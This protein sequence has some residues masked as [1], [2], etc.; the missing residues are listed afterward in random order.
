MLAC[1]FS[2]A[3]SF[4][5]SQFPS[6]YDDDIRAAVRKY[7]GGAPD[8]TWLKAQYWQESL[9]DPSQVSP[10]GAAG[11]AQFMPGSWRDVE[12][13]LGWAD[14][15][16][17]AAKYAIPAGA[18]YMAS[19]RGAWTAERTLMERHRLAQASYN[20]GI[21]NVLAAQRLCRDARLWDDIA[22]CLPDVTG[23][24]NA[25]QTVDYVAKIA[26]WQAEMVR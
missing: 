25:R 21:G 20:A 7:W 15:D 14:V 3:P 9:L 5:A 1:V 8:W 18:F 19:L 10:A 17:H 16:P 23:A 13:S 4:A 6:R 11:I 24:D 26:K 12:R 22:P 2:P